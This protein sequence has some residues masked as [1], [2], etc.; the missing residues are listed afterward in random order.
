MTGTQLLLLYLS[1]A[2]LAIVP[3]QLILAI[4][5]GLLR[6][7]I[8]RR[9][10]RSSTDERLGRWLRFAS[11]L[12]FVIL[13]TL[14]AIGAGCFRRI[15]DPEMPRL[16]AG[17]KAVVALSPI[18]NQVLENGRIWLPEE[19]SSV[20][21]L[22]DDQGY[23]PGTR[24]NRSGSFEDLIDARR[25]QVEFLDGPFP[26]RTGELPRWCLRPSP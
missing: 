20:Q 6:R 14:P 15:M 25:V 24:W 18:P 16:A 2:I 4:G 5:G 8:G 21:I 26:N 22:N 23:Q 7:K 17:S 10:S 12:V 13:A 9:D 1:I 19:G 3:I 11:A